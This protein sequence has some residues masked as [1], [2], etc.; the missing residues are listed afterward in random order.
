MRRRR[1]DD[2]LWHVLARVCAA[3]GSRMALSTGDR[4][5]LSRTAQSILPNAPT[6][7]SVT[8]QCSALAEAAPIGWDGEVAVWADRLAW[9]TTPTQ[10]SAPV[11]SGPPYKR[12]RI[13]TLSPSATLRLDRSL[14]AP[15]SILSEES[16][17][18]EGLLTTPGRRARRA[19]MPHYQETL[20]VELQDAIARHLVVADP[21]GALA[22]AGASTQQASIV[23]SILARAPPTFGAGMARDAPPTPGGMRAYLRAREVLERTPGD[24]PVAIALC[25][26]EALVRFLFEYRSGGADVSAVDPDTPYGARLVDLVSADPRLGG[27]RDRARAWYRWISTTPGIAAARDPQIARLMA[28]YAGAPRDR[29]APL[30]LTS[31]RTITGPDDIAVGDS[32]V[33]HTGDFDVVQPLVLLDFGTEARRYMRDVLDKEPLSPQAKARVLMAQFLLP[34]VYGSPD[35]FINEGVRRHLRGPCAVAASALPNFTTLFD[36]RFYIAFWPTGVALMASI[37]SPAVERL[38]F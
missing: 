4:L 3:G 28:E 33:A 23:N 22:L 35:R 20:P 17:G 12:R 27:P 5:L 36:M 16:I 29:R 18:Q 11:R 19:P 8:Q 15:G 21:R 30:F 37:G 9:R 10:E 24:A 26:M 25:L 1:P 31:G 6:E 13:D 7:W 14:H 2:D 32:V 38:L 34:N